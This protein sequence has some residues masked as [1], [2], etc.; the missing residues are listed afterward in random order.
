[1]FARNLPYRI[2]TPNSRSNR[3]PRQR[4][5]GLD[6]CSNPSSS[7]QSCSWSQAEHLMLFL[8]SIHWTGW[9]INRS[10][11]I[12]FKRYHHSVFFFFFFIIFSL[13]LC[14]RS[15]F[16]LLSFDCHTLASSLLFNNMIYFVRLLINSSKTHHHT[17]CPS[18]VQQ[19]SMSYAWCH[20]FSLSLLIWLWIFVGMADF[21]LAP[22][23]YVLFFQI[24]SQTRLLLQT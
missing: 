16:L 8:D 12:H 9:L 2:S 20:L 22:P 13:S 21:S 14:N 10:F 5:C 23:S 11:S 3:R 18:D 1:M 7:D 17:N 19:E 15:L 4:R 6:A 24:L